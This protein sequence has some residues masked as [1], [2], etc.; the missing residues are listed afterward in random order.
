[1][2]KKRHKHTSKKLWQIMAKHWETWENII[3][4][5]I[6]SDNFSVSHNFYGAPKH[7]ET[8]FQTKSWQ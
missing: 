8:S 4:T 5:C 6:N 1:V 2:I 3:H 7:I